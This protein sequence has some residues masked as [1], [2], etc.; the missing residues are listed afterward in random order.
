MLT[1]LFTG[2]V[3]DE[4]EFFQAHVYVIVVGVF[5]GV[6]LFVIAAVAATFLFLSVARRK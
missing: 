1:C 3:E 6:A 5:C 4:E 2:V